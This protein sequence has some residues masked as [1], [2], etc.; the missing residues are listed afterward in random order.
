MARAVRRSTFMA[1]CHTKTT[2]GIAR[3]TYLDVWEIRPLPFV[4]RRAKAFDKSAVPG[5]PSLDKPGGRQGLTRFMPIDCY[6]G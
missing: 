6:G 2:V 4:H 3:N 1:Y 5:F